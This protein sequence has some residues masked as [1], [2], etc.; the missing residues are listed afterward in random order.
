MKRNAARLTYANASDLLLG[1]QASRT[2]RPS[3]TPAPT[4]SSLGDDGV[5]KKKRRK[6]DRKLPGTPN[7]S[8]PFPAL[9]TQLTSGELGGMRAIAGI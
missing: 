8:T 1:N 4:N 7:G 3:G 2:D 9:T 6:K 5:P